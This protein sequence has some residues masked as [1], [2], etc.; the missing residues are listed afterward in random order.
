M[1]RNWHH[2]RGALKTGFLAV[3]L[4]LLPVTRAFASAP[5]PGRCTLKVH[6]T[7]FRNENGSADAAVFASPEGWPEGKTEFAHE[8]SPISHAQSTI[9]FQLPPGRYSVVV[10][11]D[12][13]VNYKLDRGMF[14]IPKEGFGFSNNP[15][16]FLKAPS[17]QQA[18]INVSCPVTDIDVKIIYK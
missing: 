17:F 9:A 12:E 5:G 11:H 8:A 16:V 7:G 10:L 2:C 14:G 3:S 1:I 18:S 15:R 4:L 6:A 13:N